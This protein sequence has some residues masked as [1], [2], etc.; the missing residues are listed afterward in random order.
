MS[1]TDKKAIGSNLLGRRRAVSCPTAPVISNKSYIGMR[2]MLNKQ[3]LV[4]H[5][6]ALNEFKFCHEV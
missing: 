4:C 3:L 2:L 1:E 5:L 6:C